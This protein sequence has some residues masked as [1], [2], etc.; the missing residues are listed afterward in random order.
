MYKVIGPCD[1]GLIFKGASVERKEENLDLLDMSDSEK[2]DF[3][4]IDVIL[5][6]GALE[7]LLIDKGISNEE[8]IQQ[9]MTSSHTMLA[10]KYIKSLQGE[11][12]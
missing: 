1:W 9:Y 10:E 7:K 4:L 3:M 2:K 6:M 8:E 5:R 12:D 11:E